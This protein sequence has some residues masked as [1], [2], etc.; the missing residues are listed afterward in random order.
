MI[1]HSI[2]TYFVFEPKHSPD[3]QAFTGFEFVQNAVMSM[4]WS[5][6]KQALDPLLVPQHLT[7]V[8][9]QM[10]MIYWPVPPSADRLTVM[11]LRPGFC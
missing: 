1:S 3:V 5:E 8:S 6:K 2:L 10:K 7:S 11:V 4:S 9:V